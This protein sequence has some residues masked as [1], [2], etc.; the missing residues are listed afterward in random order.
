[1]TNT[2]KKFI[3]KTHSF[4][5]HT[6]R[7][8]T[9]SS[10]LAENIPTDVK[11]I[12]DIGCG[13][14]LISA[15]IQEKRIGIKYTGIDIMERPKCEINYQSFDG[16]NIPFEL[17]SFDAVQLIDVL[18]HVEDIKSVLE[19]ALNYSRKYIIIKDH[20]Y[21]SNFDFQTLKFM[22]WIG[23]A[24]HGVKVIYNFQNEKKWN[25][26]FHDLSLKKAFYSKKI[27]LYPWFA[28]WFFGRELHFVAILEIT[29]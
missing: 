3:K 12:L 11:T 22:D 26:F 17:K 21:K 13:D 16:V 27:N 5:V 19:N 8:S 28:N 1:M 23:N 2:L 29:Y 24:P 20:L 10:I 9:I 7:V 18:H 14:G 25:N 15:K 6:N 4:A